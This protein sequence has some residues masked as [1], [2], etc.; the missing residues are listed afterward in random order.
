M[1]AVVETGVGCGYRERLGAHVA[2]AV[3][4]FWAACRVR[5]RTHAGRGVSKVRIRT[6]LYA[7]LVK[8]KIQP[9][10]SRPR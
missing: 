9:T 10:V 4:L 3:R 6:R 7:A 8:V 2:S 5:G 1:A